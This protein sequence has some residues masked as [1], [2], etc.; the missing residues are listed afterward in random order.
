MIAAAIMVA[1]EMP[2]LA[3]RTIW[4]ALENMPYALAEYGPDGIYPEGKVEI[5]V[6]ISTVPF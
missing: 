2:A 6:R 5:K 4:R 1:D 3:A